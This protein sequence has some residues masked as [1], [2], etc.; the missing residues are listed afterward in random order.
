MKL[1]TKMLLF[2]LALVAIS[3]TVKIFCAPNINLS[4]FTSLLG[5]ALFSGLRIQKRQ[6]AFLLPIGVLFVTDI[7][8]QLLHIANL[9]PFAGFYKDQYINY[10]LILAVSGI[11]YLLRNMRF[12]GFLLSLAAGPAFYFLAS[13][14]FVWLTSASIMGYSSDFNGLMRCY[15]FGL[16][17]YRN[18][19]ISTAI[20]LPVFIGSYEWLQHGRFSLA[21]KKA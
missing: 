2:C 6:Y 3:V 4:G 21:F 12:P 19:L 17:F 14:F 7:F 18:S 8:I 5:I 16:P 1:H 15:E 10:L 13:N 20:F 9:F 11:G